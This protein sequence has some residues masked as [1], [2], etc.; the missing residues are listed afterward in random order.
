M[1]PAPPSVLAGEK[2]SNFP[3][4]LLEG[5]KAENLYGSLDL[6]G[7]LFGMYSEISPRLKRAEPIKQSKT[8]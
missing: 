1:S 7:V 8:F 3:I 5:S 2:I 6:S 4:S